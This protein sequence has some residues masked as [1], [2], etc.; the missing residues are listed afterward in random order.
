MI[1]KGL[2]TYAEIFLNNDKILE[3]DN[4]FRTYSIDCKTWLKKGENE[5]RIVFTSAVK[6]TN[7]LAW[8]S[9]IKYPDNYVFVRKPSYHFGWDWGPIYITSGIWQ[10]VILKSWDKAQI[11][12]F[13]LK[14]ISLTKEVAQL[15]PI[16][17]IRSASHQ[18]A[19]VK[20]TC[21]ETGQSNSKN[22]MLQYGT[23]MIHLPIE[24]KN[25]Q[26]W[27]SNGLGKQNL[28]H[29]SAKVEIEEAVVS[30]KTQYTGLRTVKVIQEKD[31]VGSS[32]KVE[33]NGVSIF[34][35]GAD[36][37]PQDMFLAR[38]SKQDYE[39]V[40][41]QATDAN[42]N[43]LRIWGGGFFEKDIFYELCD[44]KGLLIWHDF[45]F[46]CA[47][48]P[49]N[50]AFLNNVRQ[51]TIDNIKRLRNHPSIALWCGNNENYIG[52]KDWKW[53][54]NYSKKDSA[55]LWF[56]YEKLYHQ[57]LPEVVEVYDGSRFYWPS[58]PKYGWGYPV[59]K[60][61]DVH[62]WGVWHAKEPFEVFGK[63][64][65]IGRF[66]SEYGFQS[67]TDLNAVK[68]Y[69]LPQDREMSSIVMKNHQKH[70]VGYPVIDKYFDW[71]YKKPNNFQS[72]LYLSQVMQA[73]GVGMGIEIHRRS[74][75]HC[76]GTLYWQLNDCWPVSSWASTDYYDSW[77]ALHYKVRDLF[78]EFVI[79]VAKD[80]VNPEKINFY[81][82]SDKLQDTKAIMKI[83][84][85]D[86]NGKLI[87]EKNMPVTIS[88]NNSKIM[89]A[90]SKN[91]LLS[92]NA[93]DNVVVFTTLE[94]DQKEVASNYFYF[95][96]P[97][98]LQLSKAAIHSIVTEEPG[99]YKVVLSN[100]KFVKDLYVSFEEVDGNFSDN[101]FD[102][103]PNTTKTIHFKTLEKL[104]NP[105]KILKLYS[106]TDSF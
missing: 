94:V 71:Y 19:V 92:N 88:G 40:I 29:F 51:E 22:V 67:T 54:K 87:M 2:D 82:I 50:E 86:F 27:W 81:L 4:F 106:L 77:K 1:F 65:N 28:Y 13:Q 61:G 80:T 47:M 26:L 100:D 10:P 36:Y 21:A 31:T 69:T 14:Q 3:T 95:E 98:K 44:Q 53:S 49:G 52:W 42:M 48:Y 104:V 45:M 101:Y 7:Q 64:E 60:D 32:F 34:M 68:K 83:K 73:F 6:K 18:H 17:E 75:P 76:M 57:L 84:A 102:M 72:Y 16:V 63:K 11:Q 41:Q 46:A 35:K 89:L 91:E 105:K 25:P 85:L 79:S 5:L 8:E 55:S 58:S 59:N 103:L 30:E 9:P 38:P 15:D 97:K 96:L 12:D 23:N 90:L 70:R 66:M 62:Y 39:G 78:K 99:G 37:I 56:D 20:I 43:M 74:M 93:T 33:L 24:I